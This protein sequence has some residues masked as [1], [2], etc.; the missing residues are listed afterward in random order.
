MEAAPFGTSV[1]VSHNGYAGKPV[2]SRQA[3]VEEMDA[4]RYRVMGDM[5]RG[6]MRITIGRGILDR[7]MAEVSRKY[8]VPVTWDRPPLLP[9][10][11]RR[12]SQ[13]LDLAAS[14]ASRAL[15]SFP[16]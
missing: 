14:N 5:K 6:L 11:P 16:R 10:R 12:A 15:S 3:A 9:L 1:S 4:L 2:P 8:G 7:H 13:Q